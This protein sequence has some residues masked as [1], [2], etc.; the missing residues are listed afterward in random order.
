M[1]QVSVTEAAKLKKCSD[2]AIRDAIKKELLDADLF[3]RT[4]VVKA[5]RKFKA[6]TPN[7]KAQKA[8]KASWKNR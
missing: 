3:G 7:P 6:W 2:Q 4:Y 1:N 8:A 5:N